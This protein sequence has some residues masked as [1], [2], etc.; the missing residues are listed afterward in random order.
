MQ[1]FYH[2]RKS[3]GQSVPHIL[4]LTASPVMRS[5][6]LSL[7][8]I[9]ETLDAV[10]R[11]PIAHRSELR[12][13]VKRPILEQITYT[14]LSPESMTTYT[15]T[16]ASLG[17]AYT[18]LK[19]SDDP[20]V[21]DLLKEN[22]EKSMRKLQKVLLNRKTWCQNQIRSIYALSLTICSELGGWAA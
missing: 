19:I 12:L 18:E 16:I 8:K 2:T 20:Y 21:L 6:P 13:Q 17:Q 9:E 1:G 4:G 3:K 5:D 10:C 15:A 14:N 11:A 22:T 7:T